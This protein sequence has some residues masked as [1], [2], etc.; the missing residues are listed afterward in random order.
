MRGNTTAFW[1][2]VAS[3]KLD[4]V[5]KEL[6]TGLFEKEMAGAVVEGAVEWAMEEMVCK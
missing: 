3:S 5:V 2:A 6:R 1:S 4:V